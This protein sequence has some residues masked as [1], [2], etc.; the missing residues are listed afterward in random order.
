MIFSACTPL[1]LAEPWRLSPEDLAARLARRPIQEC[2]PHAPEVAGWAP[3][4]PGTEDLVFAGGGRIL[5]CLETRRRLLPPAVL[6]QALAE[7]AARIERDQGR[8]LTHKR[9][10]QLKSEIHDRLLP[11]AFVIATRTRAIIDP[12]AGWLLVDAATRRDVDA[13]TGV[14]RQCLGWLILRP[15]RLRQDLPS[16]LTGCLAGWLGDDDP[17]ADGIGPG[18]S[19]ALVGAGGRVTLRGDELLSDGARAHLREG[20]RVERLGVKVND[21]LACTISDRLVLRGLKWLD[22]DSRLDAELGEGETSAADLA[23]AT[24]TLMGGLLIAYLDWLVYSLSGEQPEDAPADPDQPDLLWPP[25]AAPED[26]PPAAES[27][28]EKALQDDVQ[29]KCLRWLV[30]TPAGDVNWKSSLDKAA[31]GT[32]RQAIETLEAQGGSNKTALKKLNTRLRK[33]EKLENAGATPMPDKDTDPTDGSGTP[34]AGGTPPDQSPPPPPTSTPTAAQAR[35]AFCGLIGMPLKAGQ[36]TTI[37]RALIRACES[38]PELR[39]LLDSAIAWL[40][41]HRRPPRQPAMRVH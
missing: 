33:L 17:P 24:A 35:A 19:A 32:I 30:L 12:A 25:G 31:A 16:V 8:P 1:R 23:A 14:L 5:I 36:Q 11:Q 13:L 40:A 21:S 34:P 3:A 39:D 18:D 7:E 26:C 4:L 38:D 22:F 10:T 15:V 6:R 9:R 29:T 2:P 27:A 37:G 20:L 28:E 41:R